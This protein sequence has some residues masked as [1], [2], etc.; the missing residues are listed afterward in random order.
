MTYIVRIY[1]DSL[2]LIYIGEYIL[3]RECSLCSVISDYCNRRMTVGSAVSH[4]SKHFILF[5]LSR[6]SVNTCVIKRLF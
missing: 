6:L 1:D 4:I 2:Y 3:W 5:E